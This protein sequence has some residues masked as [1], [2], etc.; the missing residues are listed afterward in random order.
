MKIVERICKAVRSKGNKTTEERL[1]KL[2]R[3]NK[4]TGWRRHL[5]LPGKARLH[6][7][8]GKSNGICGWM[9]LA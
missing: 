7:Q 4:I 5:P 1:I 2:F 6:F 9:L 3:E 8:K